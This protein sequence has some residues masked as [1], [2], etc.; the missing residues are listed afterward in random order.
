MLRLNLPPK[1]ANKQSSYRY[2]LLFHLHESFTLPLGPLMVTSDLGHPQRLGATT[3]LTSHTGTGA[4]LSQGTCQPP[5]R[6]G[7]SR[8]SRVPSSS[9]ARLPSHLPALPSLLSLH[10]SPI[11]TPVN[12]PLVQ[13]SKFDQEERA[14]LEEEAGNP[15]P[16]SRLCLCPNSLYDSGNTFFSLHI[17]SSGQWG[18]DQCF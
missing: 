17:T 12:A 13:S 18:L 11:L 7:V 10:S 2:Q 5:W 8:L 14:Q 6:P 15:G 1:Q 16:R 4:A 3:P 9:G